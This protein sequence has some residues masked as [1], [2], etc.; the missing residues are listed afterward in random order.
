MTDSP[1]VPHRLFTL[2]EANELLP[3]LS[4][5]IEGLQRHYR[6]LVTEI[7][8]LGVDVSDLEEAL[9]QHR[10]NDLLQGCM[11]EISEGI[12]TIE[13][14][15]CHFKGLDLGLVDFPSL[16]ENEVAYLCWQ[17]G[18]EVVG[19]WHRMDEGFGGRQALGPERPPSRLN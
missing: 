8:R 13:S 7:R 19:F 4:R 2:D 15:G 3:Q 9:A 11:R 6:T 14:L 18:E 5:V 1:G 16:I 10:D 12:S 17:Y